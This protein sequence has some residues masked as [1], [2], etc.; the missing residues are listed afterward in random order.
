MELNEEE[1][2]RLREELSRTSILDEG[3]PIISGLPKLDQFLSQR[4]GIR[5][6]RVIEWGAPMGRCSRFLILRF[7][8]DLG[9]AVVWVYGQKEEIQIYAPAWASQGVDLSLFFFISSRNPLP[10]LRPLFLEPAFRIMVIDCPQKLSAGDWSFICAKARENK[11]LI[12]ILRPFFLSPK[13]GNPLVHFRINCWLKP[14]QGKYSLKL[15][16]GGEGSIE[17]P[18]SMVRDQ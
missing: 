11:Q 17:I 12:F 9:E 16:K 6:G 7:L 5:Y 3:H 13:R 15:L 14:S 10:D 4:G 1:A 18:L 2:T 8:R